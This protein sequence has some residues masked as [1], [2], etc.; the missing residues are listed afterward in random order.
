MEWLTLI[1]LSFHNLYTKKKYILKIWAFLF[2]IISKIVL[3][4][5]IFDENFRRRNGFFLIKKM[6]CKTSSV[7][8]MLDNILLCSPADT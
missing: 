5:L 7:S 4:Y 2:K 3:F 8:Y 6:H 1:S